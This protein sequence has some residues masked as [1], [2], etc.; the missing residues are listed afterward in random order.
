MLFRSAGAIPLGFL[1]AVCG[2]AGWQQGDWPMWFGPA[3]FSPFV[4]DATLTLLRRLARGARVWEAHREHYYQR[5]VQSG[6]GHRRTLFA[7]FA[8]MILVSAVAL[9]GLQ[10][11]PSLQAG[12]GAAIATLYVVLLIV[13]ERKLP[14]AEQHNA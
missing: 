10:S 13:F 8:L 1:A 5:L 3:V 7:E 9:A 6:L 14:L 2:I 4:V 11:A 12:A